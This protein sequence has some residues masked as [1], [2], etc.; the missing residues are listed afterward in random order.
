MSFPVNPA[1]G[2]T[3]IVNDTVFVYDSTDDSWT[4]IGSTA[5]STGGVL[6]VGSDPP[7]PVFA[8]ERVNVWVN[9]NTGRQYLYIDDG[10]ST[11]WVEL[12]TGIQ[13]ATGPQ[14]ATGATGSPGGA[15][16]ATGIQGATGPSGGATGATGP[17]GSTGVTGSQGATG[18][19]GSTG[20]NGP[21]GPP[22][23]T[24]STGITGST[25][26]TGLGATGATGPAGNPGAP[27]LTGATGAGAIIWTLSASGSSAYTLSGPG[28]YAGNTDNPVLYVYRGFAYTFVNTAGGAHPLEIRVSSG[29]AAYTTGVSGS[30]T[31]TQTFVVPMNAPS[32]LYYQCIYHSSMGNTINVI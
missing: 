31:G 7:D 6:T 1:N 28:I 26:A 30:S 22:G 12:G 11:Q 3:V 15:T 4:R 29:G 27:G 5:A 2:Q 9:A 10:N 17:A 13:G 16:G 24:G 20:V 8:P 21:A 18:S 25:G 19:Q 32:T 14:G 23:A